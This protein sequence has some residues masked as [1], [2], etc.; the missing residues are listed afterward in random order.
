YI[1]AGAFP[2]GYG[3]LGL[4]GDGGLVSGS[5]GNIVSIDTT[6]SH[7]LNQNSNYY[8][9]TVNSPAT[10][11]PLAANWDYVDGYT[12]VVKKSAFGVSG[13]GG[14]R[15]PLVHNS[16]PKIGNGALSPVPCDETIVNTATVSAKFGATPISA[17]ASASVFVDPPNAA[18][19][20]G[21]DV[22][23]S[24]KADSNS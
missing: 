21:G 7:N 12:V 17:Q 3:T 22:D 6:I 10:N 13:F 15:T 23:P 19:V 14:V 2:S 16:P 11:S 9:F 20:N 5:S 18:P 24:V 8:G 4:G 1:S